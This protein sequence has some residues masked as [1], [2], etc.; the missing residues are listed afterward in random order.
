MNILKGTDT[1]G[2]LSSFFSN[3]GFYFS[4]LLLWSFKMSVRH[5]KT[6]VI[7]SLLSV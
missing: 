2:Y 3:F 4:S 5:K 6:D 1:H 7:S